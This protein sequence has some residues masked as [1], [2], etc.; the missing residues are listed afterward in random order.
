MGVKP[1]CGVIGFES[2]CL[3]VEQLQTLKRV[4]LESQIRGKHASG[5]AWSDADTVKSF[6][7]PIP[8]SQLVEEFDWNNLKPGSPCVAIA[9]ARYSTSDIK[10]N[11]PI[12]HNRLAIAHNGVIT[13]APPDTWYDKYGLKCVTRNDSELLLVAL[14][15]NQDIQKIFASSSISAVVIAGNNLLAFRN[16]L[17]P[18]WYG[19]ACG[20]RIYA[21]TH[22]ILYRSNVQNIQRV[23]NSWGVDY[24]AR[25]RRTLDDYK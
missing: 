7:K 19:D 18:L 9:H 24:Q 14:A 10:Y 20:A 2:N 23:E 4:M 5:I 13:Q 1:M 6:V 16:G 3:T 8:I 12:V 11:Q 22:D 17:R 25:N 15:F 21:S